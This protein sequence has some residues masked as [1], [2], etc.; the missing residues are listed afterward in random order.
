[1]YHH[2]TGLSNH[3]LDGAF[4]DSIL[5]V[6]ADTTESD[7][8]SVFVDSGLE[9]FGLKDAVVGVVVLD[10]E[11]CAGHFL[12]EEPLRSDSLFGG[13]GNLMDMMNESGGLVNKD[14]PS[15][16]PQALTLMPTLEG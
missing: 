1:M 16:V 13:E 5:E 6:S 4:A 15:A 3:C 9:G 11:A 14:S 10:R 8:L 12:F 7:L 2:R